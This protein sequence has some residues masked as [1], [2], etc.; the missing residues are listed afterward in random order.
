VWLLVAA[1]WRPAGS[2]EVRPGY[3]ELRATATD[4][5]QV[6]WKQPALGEMRL[7]IDPVFPAN[8]TLVGERIRQLAEGAFLDRMTIACDGGLAGKT[9]AI[10]GLEATLTDVLVRIQLANGRAQTEILKPSRPSFAV[11]GSV[12]SGGAGAYFTL[13]VEHILL[14]VDHLLFVLGLMLLV[15]GRWLLF[16]T[17]TA[18]TLGHSA[19]LAL[20]TLG[21]VSVPG[22]PLNAAIALSIVF[23]AAEVIR[24]RRG[25]RHLTARYPWA[26]AGVFGL[27]HGL[28]FATAL[29]ALGLPPSAVPM[30]LVLFNVGVE[31]GQL[32]FI[33]AVLALGLAWRALHLRP[34][35]W[36][37]AAP[38]YAI[39]TI[40]AFWFAQR[41][42][43][44]LG[45]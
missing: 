45:R 31:L 35:A 38:L 24:S 29:T 23:L 20:A 26:I 16:K 13:G 43:S 4:R 21:L 11:S 28:G 10:A 33:A 32:A 37:E 15:M 7:K 14:G 44:V 39:G 41:V 6:L 9:V 1:S 30:A 27:L 40:A 12:P 19:S 8:C 22:P 25:E 3:L 18:F 17:I 36:A 5:Y 42:S 2:H 34:A